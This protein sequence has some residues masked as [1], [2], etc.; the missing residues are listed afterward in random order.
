MDL[1]INTFALIVAAVTIFFI[2]FPN[3]LFPTSAEKKEK[4]GPVY[5]GVYDGLSTDEPETLKTIEIKKT[6]GKEKVVAG[7]GSYALGRGTGMRM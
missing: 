7:S 6:P 1:I 2:A 5:W 3:L 4:V